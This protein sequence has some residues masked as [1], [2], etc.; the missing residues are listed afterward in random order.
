LRAGYA[1]YGSPFNK[2]LNDASKEYLTMGFGLQV[3]QYFFD[4]A[5]VN[6]TSQEDLYIYDGANSATIKSEK[7][8]ILISAG[9]KF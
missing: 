1:K 5:L 2:N 7:K 3:D 6:S 4:F 8:Q 9:F